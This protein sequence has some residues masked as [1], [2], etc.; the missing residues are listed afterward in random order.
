M[1]NL[2]PDYKLK[3][4]GGIWLFTDSQWSLPIQGAEGVIEIKNSSEGELETLKPTVLGIQKL[5]PE[6]GSDVHLELLDE[7]RSDGQKWLISQSND[8]DYFTITNPK[9]GLMLTAQEPDKPAKV[10]GNDRTRKSF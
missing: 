10:K 9:T 4:K 2:T 8:P 1:W 7:T 5:T 3:T 6:S